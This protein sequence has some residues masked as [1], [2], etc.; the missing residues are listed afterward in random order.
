[1]ANNYTDDSVLGIMYYTGLHQSAAAQ[2]Q[3]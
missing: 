2:P 3:P 1:M